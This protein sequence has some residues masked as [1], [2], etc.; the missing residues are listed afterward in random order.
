MTH[1]KR[2]G[3]RTAVSSVVC[4]MAVAH[5]ICVTS[6]MSTPLTARI[7]YPTGKSALVDAVM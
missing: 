3:R 1:P 2:S 5:S 7:L 6:V 4:R